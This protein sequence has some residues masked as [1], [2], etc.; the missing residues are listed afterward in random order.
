MLIK[1]VATNRYEVELK[2]DQDEMYYICYGNVAGPLNK[3]SE[4]IEDYKIAD[5]L[6]ELKL[7]EYEGN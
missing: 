3:K 6:F 4:L 7:Q 5:I 2:Q 1:S